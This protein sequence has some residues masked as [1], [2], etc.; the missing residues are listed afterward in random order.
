VTPAD[1]QKLFL[2]QLGVRLGPEM[3]AYVLR[4]LQAGGA[5]SAP[6]YYMGGDARTGVP[7]RTFVDPVA[8]LAD[9]PNPAAGPTPG[10]PSDPLLH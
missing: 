2:R 9:G 8:L 3:G 7:V 5:V 10:G 6:V 1:V 4:R